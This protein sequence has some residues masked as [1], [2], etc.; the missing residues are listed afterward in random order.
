MN[1]AV[2]AQSV[3]HTWDKKQVSLQSVGKKALI[4]CARSDSFVVAIWNTSFGKIASLSL[5]SEAKNIGINKFRV[6][7]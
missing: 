5:R 1:Q 4:S 2:T 6:W 3:Y 7:E